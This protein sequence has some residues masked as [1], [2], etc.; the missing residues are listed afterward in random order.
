MNSGP[1][2]KLLAHG[3]GHSGV[4]QVLR[5]VRKHLGMDVAFIAHFRETDRVFE[6][7]DSDG[8]APIE[9]GQSIP[10]EDGYCLKIVRGE[11]PE[12]IPDTSAVPAAMALPATQ[13]IPIGAHLSVPI[14][15]SNGDVY[16]TLCCF[17]RFP[18]LT[19]GERD[20]RLI[21]ALGEVLASRIDED[22]AGEREKL[23]AA[24]EIR[25]VMAM[26]APRIVYQPIYSLSKKGMVGV[27]C[28][29][30]FDVEPRRTPDL[31]F[32]SA[33]HVGL[34]AELELR[35]IEN[36]LG[37]LSHL[38]APLSIS[39]NGSPETILSGRLEEVLAR[40]DL[41]RVILE[42]TEHA[43]VADYDMLLRALGPL[44]ARGVRLAI[45]DA[46]AG[47]ASMRHI[48]NLKAEVIKLD[49]SL[50]RHIDTDSSRRALAK[51]LIAFAHEI[52]A[53]IT[54]EGVETETELAT[55]RAI[56]ADK[57]QGYFLSK[58]IGLEEVVVLA[59]S[60][61]PALVSAAG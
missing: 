55:L 36:A 19:L 27:E 43:A 35:A 38:P 11:L 32:D 30:R 34:G 31:W 56:G 51:G 54:A 44:R 22:L 25:R 53:L 9:P 37:A 60:V 8:A 49:M 20:L 33:H 42:I 29:A 59:E 3:V 47:Y 24:A 14:A 45:D 57:V 28:L 7:V 46:G 61:S 17:S 2:T 23:E 52:G 58:P 1:I 16:G 18:N 6:H 21:R 41:T 40:V 4:A 5:T 15:L 26:G 50:T 39:L 13:A 10:L 12:L 48:L